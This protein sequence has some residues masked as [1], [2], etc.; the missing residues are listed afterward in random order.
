MSSFLG[1]GLFLC[2]AGLLWLGTAV[3]TQAQAANPGRPD[4]HVRV[5]DGQN[6]PV[7]NLMFVL[8]R[9]DGSVVEP[10]AEDAGIYRFRDVDTKLIFEFVARDMKRRQFATSRSRSAWTRS[11]GR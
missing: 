11:R 7:E 10:T 1:R 3:T 6:V 9:A 4:A 2:T 5:L 8:K